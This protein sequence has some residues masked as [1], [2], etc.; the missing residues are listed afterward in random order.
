MIIWLIGL[1]GSGKT[2]IGKALY[3]RLKSSTSNLV[4]LDGDVFREILGNDLGFTYEDRQK[5][6]ARFS[7]FCKFMDEQKIHMI[8]S[9]LSNYPDWQKWNRDNFGQYFEISIDIS[10]ET[11]L[12]RETKGL[13]KKAL[14]AQ[15]KDVVG[16]DIPYHKPIKPDL[17]INNNIDLGNVTP[18]VDTIIDVLP[19]L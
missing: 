13:Y 18:I 6:A 17:V 9:V 11:L 1:S 2:T 12:K 15:I 4:F 16:V 10:I 3:D 8:C 19:S 7:K 5:N 14:D